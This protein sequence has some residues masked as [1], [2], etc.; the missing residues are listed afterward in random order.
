LSMPWPLS[1]DICG[2][3]GMRQ[4]GLLPW[5]PSIH[6]SRSLTCSLRLPATLLKLAKVESILYHKKL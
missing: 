6:R 3:N 2:S 5:V 1:A 4:L